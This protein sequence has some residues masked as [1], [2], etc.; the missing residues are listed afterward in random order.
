MK[1]NIL[2]HTYVGGPTALLDE[3]GG[4][5]FRTDPT[6]DA[7]GQEYK[8]GPVTLHKLTGPAVT[9][10]S[11]DPIDVVLLSHVSSCLE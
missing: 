11:L 4:L 6:F 8:T 10:E 5:R 7:L 1:N 3:L 9:A 2:Q